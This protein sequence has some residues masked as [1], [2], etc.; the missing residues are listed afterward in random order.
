MNWLERYIMLE[1][2]FVDIEE[3]GEFEL[4]SK[5][6]QGIQ[7][8]WSLLSDEDLEYIKQRDINN[9]IDL[10]HVKLPENMLWG[11]KYQHG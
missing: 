3:N 1:R 8:I 5:F 2:V 11:S 6:E 10:D 4:S 9:Q 7:I